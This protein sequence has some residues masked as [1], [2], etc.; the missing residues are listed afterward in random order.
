MTTQTDVVF[1]Y[2]SSLLITMYKER[3]SD[4]VRTVTKHVPTSNQDDTRMNLV[5]FQSHVDGFLT[6]THSFTTEK[7]HFHAWIDAVPTE[8][9]TE[10]S[11]KFVGKFERKKKK[12]FNRVNFVL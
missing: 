9:V 5:E 4:T 1:A 12:K 11:C 8:S 3:I 10:K 7:Q 6:K 2:D